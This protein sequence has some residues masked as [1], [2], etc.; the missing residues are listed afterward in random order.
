MVDALMEEPLTLKDIGLS[1]ISK[2]MQSLVHECAD[3]LGSSETT[4]DV[5]LLTEKLHTA[6]AICDVAWEKL[7]TGYWKDVQIVWR[8]LYSYGSLFKALLEVK[9]GRSTPD[10]L[11][12]CDMGLLLGAPILDNILSRIA[13]KLHSR[14]PPVTSADHL[15]KLEIQDSCL[16]PVP[17]E[18]PIKNLACP[19]LEHFAKE[20]LNKEEPVII[21]KGMDYWP[22]LST[23][24]WSIRYLLEKVGGRT[25]PIE[26]GSK[27]TDEA[28]S[29]KLMT[30]SAFVD[31]YILK[32]QSRDTQIGY[33]AQHQIFDQI[34]ELRDDICIPTYCCL[35]EKDEEP[36][37][38][39]WFGPEGTVSPLH[40]DPK[41][42]L[43]AQV[44]GYKYVRLYKK[45]ETPFLYPHEDRLLENTSQV[46]VENPDF[47]KFPSFANARYSECILK[48]GEM[49]FIPPKCWH[50]VRSLS[51]SLSISFWWE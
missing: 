45:Q 21:T 23:R 38:N 40:H 4:S 17:L 16:P 26:L 50:F 42:N 10:A 51:P 27:Y 13:S 3:F 18:F 7:N 39:L 43:L 41:N 11:R 25:V 30:V 6:Q 31:T 1:H 48:P 28:W 14:L 49:L 22:A 32:E 19:S 37:M 2:P 8:H 35:G 15:E 47:E 36:D 9:L 20:Y 5:T 33:L 24:P 44:F 12:S 29:Q 46:N 34:P